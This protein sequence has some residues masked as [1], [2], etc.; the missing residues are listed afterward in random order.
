MEDNNTEKAIWIIWEKQ[1]RGRALSTYF[2]IPYIE[3][4]F[5]KKGLQRYVLS[6]YHTIK[7]LFSCKPN[8]LI[9]TNPSIILNTLAQLFR[10]II[11]YKLIVDFHNA[12]LFPKEGKNYLLQKFANF[13][14]S[15][16]DYSIVTNRKLANYVESI[17]G[18]PVVLPDALPNMSAQS[19][20]PMTNPSFF[21]V[22]LVRGG[23]KDEPYAIINELIDELKNT[24]IKLYITGKNNAEIKPNENVVLTGFLLDE[25]Y[26]KLMNDID[27]VIVLSD[28]HD[29]LMCGAYEAVSLEKP[30]IAS[31]TEV[32]R[33][34]FNKGTVYTKNSARNIYESIRKIESSFE[35][36]TREIKILKGELSE[37]W[38]NFASNLIRKI[39][40]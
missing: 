6:V 15:N 31:D 29:N 37:E 28:R 8:V 11:G 1:Q 16:A 2:E 22:M 14:V 24:N 32:I 18:K 20:R 13:L 27:A 39:N 34:Y 10:P 9:V 3:L 40:E 33:W 7:I 21:N 38:P 17:K 23:G 36:Y 26:N 25:D 5:K 35:F 19:T 30:L 12:G 4:L